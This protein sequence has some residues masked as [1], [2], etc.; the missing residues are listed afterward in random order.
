V[1]Y[2]VFLGLV[3]LTWPLMIVGLLFFMGKLESY[4]NRLDADTPEE[5]GVEPVAGSSQD[6]E[7]TIVFGDQVVGE[8]D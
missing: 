5:A 7:V 2:R 6:K 8:P 4:V 1:T 3:L